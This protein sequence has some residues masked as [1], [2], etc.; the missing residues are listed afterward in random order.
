MTDTDNYPELLS[1]AYRG[2]VPLYTLSRLELTVDE[3][4]AQGHVLA[5]RAR[6]ASLRQTEDLW[7]LAEDVAVFERLRQTIALNRKHVETIRIK[8]RMLTAHWKKVR[9]TPSETLGI[10]SVQLRASVLRKFPLMCQ[11]QRDWSWLSRELREGTY[12]EARLYE[13][14]RGTRSHFAF[15]CGPV[16]HQNALITPTAQ[17]PGS[18]SSAPLVVPLQTACSWLLHEPSQAA[19]M[20]K[21]WKLSQHR[22]AQYGSSSR[23]AG[24]AVRVSQG[25]LN[26]LLCM[27]SSFKG[28]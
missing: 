3:A 6:S 1:K 27:P 14:L 13:H 26:E 18:P 28:G 12:N 16:E 25:L 9:S 8:Q 23:E 24:H 2:K 15:V 4:R 10:P 5:V 20:L 22:M 11:N 21:N 19:E 17:A 7:I